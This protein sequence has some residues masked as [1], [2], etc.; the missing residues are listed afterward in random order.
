MDSWL[1][2]GCPCSNVYLFGYLDP[3]WLY[4]INGSGAQS[5][6][7]TYYW[8]TLVGESVAYDYKTLLVYADIN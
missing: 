8:H 1:Y 5:S 6:T 2:Y 3:L 4:S 7:H